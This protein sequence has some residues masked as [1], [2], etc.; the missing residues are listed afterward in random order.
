[1]IGVIFGAPGAGKSSLS[2]FFLKQLYETRGFELLEKTKDFIDEVNKSRIHKLSYPDKPPIFADYKV[3]F[4]VDYEEYYEPY[5]INGFYTGMPNE[6]FPVQFFPPGSKIFLSEVQRY[7]NSRK[8]GSM[9]DFASRGYEMHRHY[10]I[11]F[12]LD[13]QRPTLIDLNIKAIA[14]IFLEV[15]RMENT[16]NAAGL[17]TRSVFHCR[18]FDN[19][20]DCET[21]INTGAKTYQEVKYVNEGNIYDCFDSFNYFN[22]FLPPEGKDFKYLPF[23]SRSDAERSP[24]KIYYSFNEPKGY[25]SRN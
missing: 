23:L 16:V 21:Y 24:D 15:V 22:D 14:K 10:D 6:N 19:W 12:W 2:A 9:P 8:S 17:V 25:R 5:F 20:L 13:V 11:D 18:K 3:K 4:L 1:M 7:Y